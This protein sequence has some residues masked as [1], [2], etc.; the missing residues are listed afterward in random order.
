MHLFFYIHCSVSQKRA[1]VNVVHTV[2]FMLIS[3]TH[4][5]FQAKIGTG[6]K[7]RGKPLLSVFTNIGLF[8]INVGMMN[9][10]GGFFLLLGEIII[11][12]K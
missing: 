7:E 3:I 2:H 12:V 9:I 4:S 1:E 6:I 5:D 11:F 8:A 10:L